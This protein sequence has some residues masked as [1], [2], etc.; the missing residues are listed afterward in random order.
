MMTHFS[1]TVSSLLVFPFLNLISV[2][3]HSLPFLSLSLCTTEYLPN[4]PHNHQS[5]F[6]PVSDI[7]SGQTS[8]ALFSNIALDEGSQPMATIHQRWLDKVRIYCQHRSDHKAQQSGAENG[9]TA[10]RPVRVI[11]QTTIKEN[12]I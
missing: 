5:A 11:Q 9:R 8:I 12:Y 6:S 4:L 3:F 2:S 10:E 1:A 7:Y